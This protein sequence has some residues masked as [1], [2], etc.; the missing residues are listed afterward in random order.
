MRVYHH[1]AFPPSR[2]RDERTETVSVCVPAREEAANIARVV[3]PLVKLRE[4]G[5]IDQVIVADADSVD[6]TA[7]IARKHGADVVSQPSLLPEY[8]P[9]QGKGD[10]LWRALTVLTGDVVCFVDA[11]SE[12]F[13]AH[14][15]C[16]LIGPL[17]CEPGV[18]YVKGAYRRP[19]KTK[20]GTDP[21]GGGRVTELMARPML[22]AFYP[23]L[24]WMSQPLAGEMAARR[25]LFTSIPFSMGY[26]VE[27][28]M[29][30]DIYAKVGPLAIAEVDLDV[31]QNRHQPLADLGP[32]AS[33]V[34]GAVH[35]RLRRAGRLSGPKHASEEIVERPPID[36]LEIAKLRK[37][38]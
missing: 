17:L 14:F 29:L 11:D 12:D 1:S 30:L 33:A 23:E 38:S 5:V 20:T 6:G 25:D 3:K 26:S 22:R 21:V 31:R 8:G 7:K 36:S 18:E 9:V 16:G 27:M 4:Q 34:M 15:A 10:A 13:G 2:L 19:F 28:G 32:M 35:T 24:T 37:A